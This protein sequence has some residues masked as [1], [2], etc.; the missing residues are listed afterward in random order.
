MLRQSPDQRRTRA[1]T[2]STAPGGRTASPEGNT[3]RSTRRKRG[4]AAGS[5]TIDLT[6]FS[7]A[8]SVVSAAP[9]HPQTPVKKIRVSNQPSQNSSSTSL[10]SQTTASPKS[11]WGND[12]KIDEINLVDVDD[13]GL[14][15]KKQKDL[16]N[17]QRSDQEKPKLS[18]FK[19]VICLDDPTD[20]AATPCG[21]MFCDL[22]LQGA[23]K[24]GQP[25][26]ARSGRCPVCR[27][28][29]N[30][31]DIVPL[32]IKVLDRIKGKGKGKA[33]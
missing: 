30:L 21:H 12:D 5:E 25:P 18:D 7:I 20:L 29:V 33:G 3:R 6:S 26:N 2:A 27:R 13:E 14:L 23:L 17:M 22:C 31:K 9:P 28:R 8:P 10:G 4:V 16:L 15:A 32:E 19:C 1:S 24:A 11:Q